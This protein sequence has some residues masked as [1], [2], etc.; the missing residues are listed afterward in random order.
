MARRDV[1][2]V[3]GARTDDA[4]FNRAKTRTEGLLSK[5]RGGAGG[6]ISD[7]AALQQTAR[8][9][10]MIS[11]IAQ[12][13]MIL[14]EAVGTFNASLDIGRGIMAGMAGDAEAMDKSLLSA[15]ESIGQTAVGA[16]GLA[17]GEAIFGDKRDA[18]A[19]DAQAARNAKRNDLAR[20]RANKARTVALGII[21]KMAEAE[22][23]AGKEGLDLELERSRIATE[24]QLEELQILNDQ[25]SNADA[26]LRLSE[27]ALAVTKEQSRIEADIAARRA[28]AAALEREKQNQEIAA[29]QER[30]DAMQRSGEAEDRLFGLE[31]SDR[32]IEAIKLR[33]EAREREIAKMIEAAK[34]SEQRVQ[35]EEELAR[36][37]ERSKREMGAVGRGSSQP[38]QANVALPSLSSG[39][40]TGGFAASAAAGR[41]FQIEQKRIAAETEKNTDETVA[42]LRELLQETRRRGLAPVLN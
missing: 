29:F 40:L 38:R 33:T 28:E 23:L 4:S 16:A 25:T 18:E 3:I 19:I 22:R 6:G 39:M 35:L 31:G 36:V 15:K 41:D 21:K 10:E 30:I 11:K 14:K 5:I 12:V 32:E 34:T 9:A 2:V 8:A 7:S 17:V 1:D 20:E 24:R 37:Q 42:V 26:S 27:A 13:A